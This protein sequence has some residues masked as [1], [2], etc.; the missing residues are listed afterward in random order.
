VYSNA[1]HTTAAL[2]HRD[3]TAEK[4]PATGP[5]LG[6]FAGVVFEEA[7]TCLG[8]DELLLLYTDGLTEA[9]RDGEFYGEERLFDLLASTPDQNAGAVVDS[10][11]ADV[12]SFSDSH[13]RDDLAMLS[14]RRSPVGGETTTAE[15]ED[16]VSSAP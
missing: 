15:A 2:V 3:G 10:V 12:M 13:L 11:I 6:A 7:E 1:G 5:L 16:A 4:L 14:V 8:L 9:R